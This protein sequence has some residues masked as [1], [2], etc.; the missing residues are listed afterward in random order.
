[1]D[2]CVVLQQTSIKREDIET[3]LVTYRN[4]KNLDQWLFEDKIRTEYPE[5]QKLDELIRSFER[6]LRDGLDKVAPER[7]K[8]ITSTRK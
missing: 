2:Y 3:K 6:N 4:L 7:I 1:M 5:D 8:K